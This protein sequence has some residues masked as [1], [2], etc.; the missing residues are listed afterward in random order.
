MR[1]LF[2]LTDESTD[3]VFE[4][5]SRLLDRFTCRITGTDAALKA[6]EAIKEL[7]SGSCDKSAT[8]PFRVH[9]GQLW[10]I[11]RILAIIFLISSVAYWFGRVGVYVSVCIIIAGA[12]YGISHFIFY[13]SL[14]DKL[15][16]GKNAQ[17]AVGI[18]E[19]DNRTEQQ[20][21]V[22]GHHDSAYVFRYLKSH[23]SLYGFIMIMSIGSYLC[24]TAISVYRF[25]F[26][27]IGGHVLYSDILMILV[28]VLSVA[29]LPLFFFITNEP[30]PGAGDNLIGSVIAVKLS[31]IF[32]K[33]NPL[34]MNLRKT[35]LVFLSTDAEEA[36]QRGVKAYIRRHIKDINDTPTFVLNIDSIY[37]YDDLTLL[38][39]DR[40]GLV[41]L[42]ALQ[43]R[44]CLDIARQLG[45]GIKP[46]RIPFGGGGT[47]ASWFVKH[48]AQVASVIGMPLNFKNKT[49]YYHTPSDT[50]DKIEPRAVKSVIELA[51]NYILD[52]DSTT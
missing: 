45:I 6:G 32:G 40:N 51:V 35:R 14:F 48:K 5:A 42:S 29:V 4:T 21:I 11:G 18:I 25:L 16:P 28:I 19:P 7:F 12:V 13:V 17:N 2:R 50:L 27:V 43:N 44:K 41:P 31:W 30:S 49:A 34:K 39:R 38:E 33:G 22:V 24:G 10:N 26:L 15:F 37:S 36:G 3:E 20:V 23:Q 47:D 9:P 46:G 52:L 8:E 1:D